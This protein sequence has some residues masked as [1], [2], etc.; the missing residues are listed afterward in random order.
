MAGWQQLGDILIYPP[1]VCLHKFFQ[2][3]QKLCSGEFITSVSHSEDCGLLFITAWYC[4][5]A[6]SL[7][8]GIHI[9]SEL[10]KVESEP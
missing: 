8:Q 4:I 9:M 5:F 3:N 1:L 2:F 6:N 10:E 7:S